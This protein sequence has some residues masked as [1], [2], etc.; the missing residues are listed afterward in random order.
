MEYVRVEVRCGGVVR[1]AKV[2]T[3]GAVEFGRVRVDDVG[4]LFL[5]VLQTSCRSRP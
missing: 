3:K 2:E 1:L 4:E 5:F